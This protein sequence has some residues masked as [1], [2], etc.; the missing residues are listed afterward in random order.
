M[1]NKIVN[2]VNNKNFYKKLLIDLF[3]DS[4]G[5]FLFAV[6]IYTFARA[7]QYATGGVSGIAL[8]INFLV[9]TLPIGA[10]T[11]ILNIPIII[12]SYKIVGKSFM[13]N[14]LRTMAILA[15]FTDIIV[16][17]IPDYTGDKIL[18]SLFSGV[19]IGMG[20]AILYI[21]NTSTGGSDFIVMSLKKIFPH[22]S[23]GQIVLILAGGFIFGNVNSVLY[24]IITTYAC[25]TVID[26]IM[27]GTGGGKLAVIITTKGYE[28]ANEINSVLDRG[29]TLINAIGTYSGK[30]RHMLI[31]VASKAQVFKVRNIA[32]NIDETAFVTITEAS[33]IY[34]EG[35]T[36]HI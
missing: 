9:P 34:G 25:T 21:R 27:Y 36:P 15:F 29:V 24:G 26:K 11:L 18:A 19:F 1:L 10:L 4:V 33:D 32:Y 13:L 16:P 5:S 22:I 31:C 20:L 7:A 2:T 12:F 30:E 8:I 3:Y 14:S 23:F 28:I 35:F 17:L 6:G